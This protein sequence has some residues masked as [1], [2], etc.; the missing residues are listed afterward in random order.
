MKTWLRNLLICLFSPRTYTFAEGWQSM[1][2]AAMYGHC[3]RME[4]CPICHG[5]HVFDRDD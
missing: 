5:W 2:I 3:S 4:N 1:K